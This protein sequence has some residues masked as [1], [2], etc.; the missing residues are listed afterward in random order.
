M[1]V[2]VGAVIATMNVARSVAAFTGLI[3]SSSAGIDKLIHQAF[4]SALMNLEMAKTASVREQGLEYVKEAR[5]RFVDAVAVE[6]DESLVMAY[7]G[8]AMC[9]YLL[10][11]RQ[12]ARLSLARISGVELSSAEK[13]KAGAK[14]FFLGPTFFLGAPGKAWDAY[15]AAKKRE[16][17]FRQFKN[18]VM[19]EMKQI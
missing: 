15:N 17:T 10:G 13:V 1:S 5:S 7:A 14:D 9:Q 6:K 3:D 8:L 2:T 18:K 12:N 11:D 19:L 16:E 4:R